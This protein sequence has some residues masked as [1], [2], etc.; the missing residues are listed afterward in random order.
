MDMMRRTLGR[1]LKVRWT[2][3]SS[4]AELEAQSKSSSSLLRSPRAAFCKNNTT[5]TYGVHF[6]RSLYGWK[7]NFKELPMALVSGPNSLGVDRNRWNKGTPRICH[8]AATPSFG[9]LACVSCWG[10]WW[11]WLGGYARPNTHIISSRHHIRVRV[12]FE[13]GFLWR[14]WI[15]HCNC[16]D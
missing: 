16:V 10:P 1:S 12:L 9:L 7:G 2:S 14:N 5:A 3:K 15:I 11:M 8:N 13:F 6:G 4:Q